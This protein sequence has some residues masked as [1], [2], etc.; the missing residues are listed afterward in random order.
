MKIY[1]CTIAILFLE[2]C[3]L[4]SGCAYIMD[5]DSDAAEYVSLE[6]FQGCFFEEY[7]W[8]YGWDESEI[9]TLLLGNLDCNKI[10]ISGDSGMYTNYTLNKAYFSL[11][12][13]SIV[14]FTQPE[15]IDTLNV[16]L[17]ILEPEKDGFF[18]RNVS[19]F[20]FNDK[21]RVRNNELECEKRT[22]NDEQNDYDYT[23]VIQ[24]R[25]ANLC[26]GF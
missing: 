10:C 3:I 2:L 1:G 11:D 24:Q 22:W 20:R 5:N 15:S 18:R 14:I 19:G 26:N 12:T 8:Q 4:C 21:C 7:F 13:T 17:K 23:W 25:K 9:D 16:Q 6:D